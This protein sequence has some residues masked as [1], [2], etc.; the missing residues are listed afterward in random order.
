[1]NKLKYAGK[2][3]RKFYE[4]VITVSRVNIHKSYLKAGASREV[5][6]KVRVVKH[7]ALIIFT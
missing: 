1:M 4:E 6:E 5:K 3:L 7:N 2:I